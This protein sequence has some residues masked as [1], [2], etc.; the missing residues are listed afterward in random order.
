MFGIS[1]E[2]MKIESQKFKIMARI[3]GKVN[4]IDDIS[5]IN[6][7]IRDEMLNINAEDE[8]V[9]LKKRS[10]YLCTLTY[11]PFWK[12]KF[13]DEIEKVRERAMAENYVTVNEA[14]DVAKYYG[15]DKTYK[16]WG[17][18]D[19]DI[20]AAVKAIPK[21]VV[22]E[23]TET[24]IQMELSTEILE[25]L[26]QLFCELRAAALVCENVA[27]LNKIKRS[28]DVVSAL[29]HLKSF[30]KHFS[31]ETMTQIDD[32][33]N[34]EKERSIELFNII[35][36]I[37]N[38]DVQYGLADVGDETSA[39][40]LI[41]NIMADETKADTYIPTEDKYKGPGKVLWLVYYLPSRKREYAKRIYLPGTYQNLHVEGPAE[42]Y[43][44]FGNPE[45]GLL[46]TYKTSIKPTV[47]HIHERE[48]QLP[49]RWVTK[50]KIVPVPETAQNIRITEEKP[51]AAMRIA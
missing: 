12:K 41:D 44:R 11:S 29:P 16:P 38:Y 24:I 47:I 48:I 7:I 4:T 17:K 22:N 2:K 30:T 9:E 36:Q 33:I 8:L 34:V 23:L 27:C 42:Y 18:P 46:L 20:E 13:G 32:L 1:F 6:C 40:N 49:E 15:W 19:G 21:Q 14:N 50:K 10:D 51:D 39:R 5:R 43:N 25:K 37:N 45:Y 26:R 3:Y 31:D 28:L 35:S